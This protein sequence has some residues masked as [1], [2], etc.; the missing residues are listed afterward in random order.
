[1]APLPDIANVLR[2]VTSGTYYA[3]KWANVFHVKYDGTTPTVSDL[4]TFCTDF[5]NAYDGH[6]LEHV[7]DGVTL[8]EVTAVDL[9]SDVSASGAAAVSHPGDIA[10]DSLSASV[11]V[12]LSWHI[13]RRYRGGHPRTYLPGIPDSVTANVSQLSAGAVTNYESDAAGFMAAVNAIDVGGSPVVL[14]CVSYRFNN[15]P[16]I[17]PLFEPFT[18]SSVNSRLD[19]Q[20]RR[21]GK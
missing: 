17:T 15:A 13:S 10:G 1:M 6:L 12:C 14:G 20:R 19:S 11:S 4:N 16:R 5:G 2:V 21:L 8:T 7:S 3:T 18:S 9:T